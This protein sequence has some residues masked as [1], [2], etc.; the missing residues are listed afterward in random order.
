MDRQRATDEIKRTYFRSGDRV[1]LGHDGWYC[2]VRGGK[3]CGPYN[4]KETALHYGNDLAR[5]Q[6]NDAN[7][8]QDLERLINGEKIE[9]SELELAQGWEQLPEIYRDL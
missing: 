7:N 9:R 8:A 6:R 4:D 5:R 2:L 3:Q 1:I